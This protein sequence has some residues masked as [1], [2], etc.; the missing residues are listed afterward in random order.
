M[1][2]VIHSPLTAKTIQHFKLG[3][4]MDDLTRAQQPAAGPRETSSA[5]VCRSQR[6]GQRLPCLLHLS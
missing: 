6:R 2:T 5:F 3:E 4:L 1:W